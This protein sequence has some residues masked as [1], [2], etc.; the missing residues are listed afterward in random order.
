MFGFLKE[1]PP[2]Y[3][4]W[5]VLILCLVGS[6]FFAGIVELIRWFLWRRNTK[7]YEDDADDDY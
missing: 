1:L 5:V 6:M 2:E 4:I 7:Y 3:G